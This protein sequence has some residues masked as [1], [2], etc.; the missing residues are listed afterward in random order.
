[1]QLVVLGA[2]A[3][4]REGL[5]VV[6]ACRAAGRGDVTGDLTLLGFLVEAGFGEPGTTVHGAPLLGDLSWLSGRPLEGLLGFCSVGSPALRRRLTLQARAYGLR[7]ATLIHPTVIG[8]ASAEIGE[9]ALVQAGSVLTGG[10]RIGAHAQLYAGCLISHDSVIGEFATLSPGSRLG[11]CVTVE[12]GAFIGLGV[13]VLQKRVVGAWSIVG[14]G[15]TVTHDVP[16]DSTAV[17]VPTR[18]IARR[19]AGWH[20]LPGTTAPF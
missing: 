12:T 7:F 9:G 13:N 18:E 1:M 3:N 19:S 20:E 8:A 14:A 11:G 6:D 4:A 2:G 5:D 15:G 17:G 10:V 16:P